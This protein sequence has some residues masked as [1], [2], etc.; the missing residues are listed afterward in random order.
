MSPIHIWS[1]NGS[2]VGDRSGTL[3]TVAAVAWKIIRLLETV[4]VYLITKFNFNYYFFIYIFTGQEC[5]NTRATEITYFKVLLP[6]FQKATSIL[7]YRD[8]TIPKADEVLDHEI[9]EKIKYTAEYL[10]QAYKRVG[11][12]ANQEVFRNKVMQAEGLPSM[13][14]VNTIFTKF[15]STIDCLLSDIDVVF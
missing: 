6:L 5:S 14:T 9:I 1:K 8:E 10:H 15:K 4:S 11:K 12:L 7:M 13:Y 2:R 3:V